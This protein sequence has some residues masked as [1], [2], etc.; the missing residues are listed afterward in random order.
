M[1]ANALTNFPV[2]SDMHRAH[3]FLLFNSFLGILILVSPALAEQGRRDVLASV[4]CM[5]G[6]VWVTSGAGKRRP[7]R[8]EQ[9]LAAGDRLELAE[10]SWV[11]IVCANAAVRKIEKSTWL[12]N[13]LCQNRGPGRL[14]LWLGSLEV[15]GRARGE[16]RAGFEQRPVIVG[17]R[18]PAGAA[19]CASLLD[20]SLPLRWLTVTDAESYLLELSSDPPTFNQISLSPS[21]V[22]CAPGEGFGGRHVCSIPWPF[23]T[24][25][26]AGS[27]DYSLEVVALTRTGTAR[28]K[29]TLLRPLPA[30]QTEDIRAAL[31]RVKQHGLE[32][33]ITRLAQAAILSGLGLSNDAVTLLEPV[34]GHDPE[35]GKTSPYLALARGEAYLRIDLPELATVNYREVLRLI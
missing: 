11:T 23:E 19:G 35:P 28:S 1:P 27:T 14:T 29:K 6:E 3:I 4:V 12:S 9:V 17:P 15:S 21:E 10:D 34:P 30:E 33:G 2:E 22:V 16:D 26:M 18:C 24:W 20:R 25:A 7:V 13:P 8:P 32:P 5:D 31:E